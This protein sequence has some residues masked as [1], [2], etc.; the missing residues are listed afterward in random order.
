MLRFRRQAEAHAEVISRAR[1]AGFDERA[2]QQKFA[3]LI[4]GLGEIGGVD[5]FLAALGNKSAVFQ[6]LLKP[7]DLESL[8]LSKVELLLETVMPARKRLW[9]R[10]IELGERRLADEIESLLYGAGQVDDRLEAFAAVV[11]EDPQVDRKTNQKARRA[12]HDFGAEL[13]HFHAPSQYPLMTYWVWDPATMTGALRELV[14]NSDTATEVRIGAGAGA[15]EA[16]YEWVT[17]QLAEQGV[18][19]DP[20]YVVDLVLAQAYAD[21]VQ[22]MS[23][24]MGFMQ[25]HFGGKADPLEVVKKLLGIDEARRAG[26]RVRKH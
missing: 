25:P 6:S 14:R 8:D 5:P 19:R 9:P 22:A 1:G 2:F 10:L 21:Y 26:S 20:H 12:M 15:Y 11:P 7:G 16:G 13:L 23:S 3:T 24:G 17:E 18:Y 4:A